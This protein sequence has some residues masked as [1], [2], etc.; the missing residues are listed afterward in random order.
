M[1]AEFVLDARVRVA[2]DLPFFAIRCAVLDSAVCEIS[3]IF[4]NTPCFIEDSVLALRSLLLERRPG[5]VL[6]T[7][8]YSD[9]TNPDILLFLMGD[10]REVKNKY[11]RVFIKDQKIDNLKTTGA[12]S[13]RR[14]V[15]KLIEKYLPVET[16]SKQ[17]L[18]KKDLSDWGLI[19]D[20]P[21]QNYLKEIQAELQEF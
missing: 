16:L 1:T 10:V 5:V 14:V 9:I 7:Q 20:S 13:N 12:A 21:V 8:I 17:W 4:V 19:E 3:L 6:R 18:T 15:A 2:D 11:A